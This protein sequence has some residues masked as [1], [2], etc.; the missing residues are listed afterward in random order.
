[1]GQAVVELWAH[2][3]HAA[4]QRVADRTIAWI[5]TLPS[6]AE[7]NE[8]RRWIPGLLYDSGR[9]REA[10]ELAVADYSA[11]PTDPV[12]REYVAFI[13]AELG[14]T[15]TAR[16]FDEMM[17]ADCSRPQRCPA[18]SFISR[19][20]IA[21]HL[22][23]RDAAVQLI[24]DAVRAGWMWRSALH[25]IRAFDSLRGYAPYDELATARTGV[26][27]GAVSRAGK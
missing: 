22:G 21:A 27:V 18:D 6:N 16:R 15:A 4:A 23:D 3:H 19:A 24:R 14:D 8:L 17:V 11:H 26:G 1:M 20:A 5:R 9:P 10:R 25:F 13:A 2:G 7:G 12:A